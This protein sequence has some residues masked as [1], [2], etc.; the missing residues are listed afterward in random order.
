MD[1]WHAANGIVCILAAVTLSVIVLHPRIHEGLVVKS[2][3]ILMIMSLAATAMLTLTES[4]QLSG[5]IRASFTLRL[6]LAIACIG[7][8]IKAHAARKDAKACGID[9]HRQMTNRWLHQITEPAKD[10]AY[11][12]QEEQSKKKRSEPWFH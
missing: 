9:I 8:L 12:F 10:L 5:Y 4:T 6:G 1:F 2:G 7:I 11:L 3:L